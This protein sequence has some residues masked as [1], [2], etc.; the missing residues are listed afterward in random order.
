[1][2]ITYISGVIVE[3]STIFTLEARAENDNIILGC[4]AVNSASVLKAS[5]EVV[6][7]VQGKLYTNISST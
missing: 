7:R 2:G 5:N 6:L 1:M 4:I 3:N